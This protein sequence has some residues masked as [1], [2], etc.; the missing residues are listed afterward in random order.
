[1]HFA[2]LRVTKAFYLID[3]QLY[4]NGIPAFLSKTA[5]DA[6]TALDEEGGLR[7]YVFQCIGG[8]GLVS[9]FVLCAREF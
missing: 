5:E 6:A 9:P 3:A 4:T 1:M 2:R 7:P 8:D